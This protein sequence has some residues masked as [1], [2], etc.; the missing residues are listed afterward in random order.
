MAWGPSHTL[1]NLTPRQLT[2]KQNDEREACPICIRL[3]AAVHGVARSRTRL[4]HF[5]FTFHFHALEKEMATHSSTLAWRIPGTGEPGGLP[6]LG[7]HRVGHDWSD[8]AAAA[9][10]YQSNIKSFHKAHKWAKRITDSEATPK[11]QKQFPDF[12]RFQARCVRREAWHGQTGSPENSA[13]V[14]R[15]LQVTNFYFHLCL[16]KQ[17]SQD[18]ASAITCQVSRLLFIAKFLLLSCV[19]CAK[20]TNSHPIDLWRMELPWNYSLIFF[21]IQ[22]A[23]SVGGKHICELSCW[24]FVQLL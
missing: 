23:E 20:I 5:T 7:S 3:W 24:L 11:S 12:D 19:I 21:N 8:L 16:Q 22:Q 2:R 17:V 6:S 1:N 9:A 15:V 10:A 13:S 4:S 18:S 14:Y